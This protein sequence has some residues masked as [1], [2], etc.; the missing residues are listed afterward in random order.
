MSGR[1]ELDDNIRTHSKPATH[2]AV[3]FWDLTSELRM[4]RVA[5]TATRDIMSRR[6]PRRVHRRREEGDGQKRVSVVP[7]VP[8]KRARKQ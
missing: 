4:S 2:V 1:A 5:K 8:L 3:V 6:G 7:R